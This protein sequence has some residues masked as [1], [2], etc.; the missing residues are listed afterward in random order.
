[1][2]GE[3]DRFSTVGKA[4]AVRVGQIRRL[5]YNNVGVCLFGTFSVPLEL[6]CRTLSAVWGVD[7]TEA[8]AE[9][10]V[11]RAVNLRRAFNIRHGLKPE[12]DTLSD[13]YISQAPPDGGA[14]GSSI[15][16]KPMVSEYYQLMGWDEATGKPFRQTL[17]ELD[18]DDVAED[19]WGE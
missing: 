9:K 7:F 2:S 8:D 5:F 17:A 11:M 4:E 16:I 10:N 1:M 15:N 19:L 6:I 3:L 18:L 12:D 13:R 14:K